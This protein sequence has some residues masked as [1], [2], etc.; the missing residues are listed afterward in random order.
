LSERRRRQEACWKSVPCPQP[1][2]YSNIDEL[3]ESTKLAGLFEL[4]VQII[5]CTK[6]CI[7]VIR[8][9]FLMG[10]KQDA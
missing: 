4:I 10:R 1:W 2:R 3:D 6:A 7:E 5:P 8:M 9:V